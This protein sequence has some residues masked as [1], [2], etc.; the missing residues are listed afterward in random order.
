MSRQRW[1]ML[2]SGQVQGVF[3]RASA[4]EAAQRIGVTGLVRNC[5]DGRVEVIAEGKE[6]ALQA[7]LE[8]CRQGPPLAQVEGVDC[9]QQR[10][11]GEFPDF[12]IAPTE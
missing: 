8:W 10:A 6:P 7:M 11:T 9:Q 3:Y 5:R 4:L 1:R 2:I 12:D